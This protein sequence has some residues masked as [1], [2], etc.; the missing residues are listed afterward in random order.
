MPI[1][2]NCPHEGV[3]GTV[4]CLLRATQFISV[5]EVEAFRLGW[6][7][8]RTPS[9]RTRPLA[10]VPFECATTLGLRAVGRA[11]PSSCTM[12][13]VP[14][15]TACWHFYNQLTRVCDNIVCT[16]RRETHPQ[17]FVQEP[18]HHGGSEA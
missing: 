9:P 7:L 17:H 16:R 11:R 6:Y 3:D 10:T 14:S 2:V 1:V 15:F 8:P 13:S 18:R 12:N 4:H 5:D